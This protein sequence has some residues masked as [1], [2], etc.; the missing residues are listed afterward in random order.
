[1]VQGFRMNRMER[2]RFWRWPVW[3]LG[4]LWVAGCHSVPHADMVHRARHHE[5][6]HPQNFAACPAVAGALESGKPIP[7]SLDTVLRLAQDQNGQVRLAR[8]KLEDAENDQEW[9]NKHWMPDLYIGMG[10]YRHEGGIQ[11]FQGNLVRSSYGSAVGGLEMSGK[12]DWKEVL[13]RKV[14]AERRV[15][16]QRGEVSKLSNENLL[17]ATSTY[18]D[19]L[20]SRSGVIISIEI[21]TRLRDLLE[22]TTALAKIDPGLRVEVSRIETE[23]TA[24]AVLSVKLREASKAASAKLAYL[25]GL[26]PCC[27]FVVADKHL[28]PIRLMSANE[29]VQ[30]LVEQALTRGPGVRELEGL[31]RT[32]EAARNT[33][34]GLTHWMPAIEMNILEGGFGAGPGRQLDWANRFDLGVHMK[35]NINEF[36]TSKLKRRQADATIQQVHLSYHDLKSKLTLGVQEAWDSI[37]SGREQV[38]L[39]ERHIQSAEESY[40]LSETRLKQNIKG[41]SSSEVLLALRTLGGAKLEYLQAARDYNKAQLRLFVLVG[42]PETPV[43]TLP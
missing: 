36:A 8:M 23:L 11:D 33:N 2:G 14:E 37:H 32:V 19:L 9:A 4:L 17:D 24:Q 16:A 39:A 25:L 18:I 30:N 35:W 12:Y 41:R 21:E 38:Q 6:R 42:G 26:D 7:I 40:K 29:P 1:M 28:T 3:Y 43:Q 5:Y 13:F 10:F 27:Q 20:A 22:Q 31:L 34:Y 15:W